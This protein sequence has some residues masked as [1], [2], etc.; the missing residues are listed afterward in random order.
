M[1][2]PERW[3]NDPSAYDELRALFAHGAGSRGMTAEERAEARARAVAIAGAGVAGWFALTAIGRVFASGKFLAIATLVGA[4]GTAT[5]LMRAEPPH[6]TMTEAF[7]T[8]GARAMAVHTARHLSARTM[9]TPPPRTEVPLLPAESVATVLRPLRATTTHASH[10][11]RTIVQPNDPSLETAAPD[12]LVRESE[13]VQGAM[14]LLA[15]E[16]ASALRLVDQHARE[17]PDGQLAVERAYVRVRALARLGRMDEAAREARA[18]IA[19]H[20][21]SEYAARLSRALASSGG[22]R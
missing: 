3:R 12:P 6:A 9:P 5:M 11:T 22:L 7:P 4:V 10:T 17:F 19:A 13:L 18:L 15:S 20:P 21:A 2:E 8:G 1:T 16:P 14:R